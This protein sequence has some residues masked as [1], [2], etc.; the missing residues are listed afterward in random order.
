[1]DLFISILTIALCF[2]YFCSV[3]ALVFNPITAGWQS[4]HISL[5]VFAVNFKAL[6]YFL[7]FPFLRLKLCQQQRS[8]E[9]RE[10]QTCTINREAF[11]FDLWAIAVRISHSSSPRGPDP[12]PP[13]P[14]ELA[15]S[16]FWGRRKEVSRVQS[17][18]SNH[19]GFAVCAPVIDRPHSQGP[20]RI[21]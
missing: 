11:L 9:P 10:K 13:L 15:S 3:P 8:A 18:G 6:F 7:F 12:L 1:M 17:D 21:L 20:V 4:C 14:A 16:S 19:W 5:M 2:C